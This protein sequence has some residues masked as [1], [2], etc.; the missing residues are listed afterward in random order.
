MFRQSTRK[1]KKI[2][3]EDCATGLTLED[4]PGSTDGCLCCLFV[5]D[6]LFP[7]ASAAVSSADGSMKYINTLQN[8][9]FH[10]FLNLN[11][12]YIINYQVEVIST[13]HQS[14]F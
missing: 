13:S 9:K 4:A 10:L 6:F 5:E 8:N 12:S 1:K 7:T 14:C 11:I 3:L 2:P